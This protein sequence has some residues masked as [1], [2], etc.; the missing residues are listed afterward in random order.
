MTRS[1]S[2]AMFAAAAAAYPSTSERAFVKEWDDLAVQWGYDYDMYTVSTVDDWNLTLFRI[3][4]KNAAGTS[5]V[6]DAATFLKSSGGSKSS[7]SKSKSS[8]S[9]SSKSSSSK[10][11]SSS[12][13]KKSKK[14]KKKDKDSDSDDDFHVHTTVVVYGTSNQYY[15]QQ[16][17]PYVAPAAGAPKPSP[18]LLQHAGL[19][20]AADWIEGQEGL[21]PMPFQ[22]VDYGYDVWMSNSRGTRYSMDTGTKYPFADDPV[23]GTQYVI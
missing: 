3:T 7:S 4:G 15:G 21:T 23:Y 5:P 14:K 18:V 16:P 10:S 9:S 11:S 12:S 2:Y 20:D 6:T 17:A 22:L 19:L 1:Y 8:K 13:S